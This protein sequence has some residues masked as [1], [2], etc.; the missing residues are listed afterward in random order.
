[1]A[2]PILNSKCEVI[3]LPFRMDEGEFMAT[4]ETLSAEV[5][6]K[7]IS[8]EPW[9]LWTGYQDQEFMAYFDT[10]RVLHYD[11]SYRSPWTAC[12]STKKVGFQRMRMRS[13]MYS[14]SGPQILLGPGWEGYAPEIYWAVARALRRHFDGP[15]F[16]SEKDQMVVMA[17]EGMMRSH[18]R[19]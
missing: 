15:A 8:P 7:T 6:K 14:W 12:G 16:N 11:T 3:P 1:M 19:I 9:S 2:G 4:P 18:G 13:G 10:E 5:G 17:L